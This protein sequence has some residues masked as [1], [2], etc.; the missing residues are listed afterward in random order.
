MI[1][2]AVLRLCSFEATC[3]GGWFEGTQHGISLED[4]LNKDTS[5]PVPACL[6]LYKECVSKH[7]ILATVDERGRM[8]TNFT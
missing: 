8:G 3:F 2:H 5:K 1:L 6:L 4:P 7:F